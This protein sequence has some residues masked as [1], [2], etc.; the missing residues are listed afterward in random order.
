MS[1]INES[2]IKT[3]GVYVNEIPS[4][5]PSIAQ[6]ATAIPAFIGY[7]AIATDS[8]GNNAINQA[9]RISSL[10]EFVTYFGVGP[11]NITANVDLNP[12]NSVAK[13]GILP[14]Y[15]L[16]NSICM[17]FNNG[18]ADCYI[19]S[20]G[21]YS[22]SA[23]NI[24]DFVNAGSTT[25]M[26]LDVLK[27]EDEPTLIVIPD[28]VSL[29]AN[30]YTLMSLALQQC[31]NLQDRFTILDIPNGDQP[32][33]YGNDDVVTLFRDG[34]GSL[35]L[36]YGA[37]YYPYLKTSLPITIIYSNIKL[38]QTSLTTSLN[39]I[40]SGNNFITQITNTSTDFTAKVAPLLALVTSPL[41]ALPPNITNK[42]QLTA[43]ITVVYN[44]LKAFA[45]V[46]GFTDTVPAPTTPPTPPGKTTS[47]IYGS[48]ITPSVS[49]APSTPFEYL[50]EQLFLVDSQYPV[51]TKPGVV[52][53]GTDFA[54][55]TNLPT[56]ATVL[57]PGIT[58]IYGNVAP[59]DPNV[60]IAP[61]VISLA[62]KIISLIQSFYND[63][64]S[65]M[66]GLEQ[67]VISSSGIYANIK[68]AIN[69]A[70]IVV[71]PSGTMAGIYA[72]VDGS[73]G[74]WKAPANVS[75]NTVI[76]PM[77]NI[78]DDTQG[79]LNI[80][81]NAGKSVNAI[82]AFT[83]KGTLVWGARTLDGNSNDF[84]YISVRRFY[85]MV[86][87]SVKLAAMQFVFEPNDGST[88]VRIRAMIENYLTNLWRQGALAGAKPE[89]S[90]YVK[91]GLGQTMIF[92]DILNGRLI[93]E[94]GMAPVRPAEFII[95]RFSQIQQTS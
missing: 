51:G 33:T 29:G 45:A 46:T 71:P 34:I 80:D 43:A 48:Y 2:A 85:I 35:N 39:L 14:S 5:P 15:Q 25:P 21:L 42:L 3:P 31:G 58:S 18:G 84:R 55:Y 89:Q 49:P 93:V 19:I 73:R 1:Q 74:V 36:N 56:A 87:E 16:F 81:T 22:N 95:L 4:F 78:D 32:R 47:S 30:Y 61:T 79:D 7:T 54:T 90:F 57:P 50:L 94:I 63:A 24:L 86:E 10:I 23:T 41:N 60:F 67:Q 8:S 88:W 64:L 17:F 12:D 77:V 27:K 72:A 76:A 70:G 91:V 13:V 59:A 75:V 66:N 6:V 37:V 9:I 82:R 11:P 44:Y 20:V 52:K 38:T 65:L 68:A 53:P 40:V 28:A 26:C 62:A 83:G 92:D 69:N